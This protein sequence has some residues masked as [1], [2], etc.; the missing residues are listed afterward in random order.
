MGF[1]RINYDEENWVKIVEQLINKKDVSAILI[2][3][4]Y[5]FIYTH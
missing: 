3:I 1:Y 4:L 2:N 5:E